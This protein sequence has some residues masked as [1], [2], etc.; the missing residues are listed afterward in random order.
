MSARTNAVSLP[1]NLDLLGNI[2]IICIE[3]LS[4]ATEILGFIANN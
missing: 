4:M 3:G 1:A 2:N